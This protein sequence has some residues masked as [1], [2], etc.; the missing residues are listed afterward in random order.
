M[1]MSRELDV[2]SYARRMRHGFAAIVAAIT[3]LG[4][5]AHAQL[6]NPYRAVEDWAKLPDGRSWGSTS[7]VDVDRDGNI[8]VAERCGANFFSGW[9]GA[10]RVLHDLSAIPSTG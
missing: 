2:M 4:A 9:N 7:A 10:P 6:P 8:W 5:Q 1:R 3:L